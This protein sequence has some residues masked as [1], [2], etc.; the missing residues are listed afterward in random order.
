LISLF[1]PLKN[2]KIDNEKN[3]GAN[4][5]TLKDPI[6][7]MLNSFNQSPEKYGQVLSELPK[8]E[9]TTRMILL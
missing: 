2:N 7:S 9:P 5:G 6:G 1:T 8:P 3:N 4:N